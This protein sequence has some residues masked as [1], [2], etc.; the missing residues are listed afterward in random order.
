MSLYFAH[1]NNAMQPTLCYHVD[2]DQPC[3]VLKFFQ[4]KG[5]IICGCTS[6]NFGLKERKFAL[7]YVYTNIE[8]MERFFM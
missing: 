4:W 6:Y 8:E 2:E 3:S 5:K 1:K 7:H